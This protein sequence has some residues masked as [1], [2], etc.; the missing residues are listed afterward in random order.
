MLVRARTLKDCATLPIICDVMCVN[1]DH[2]GT[3]FTVNRPKGNTRRRENTNL[4]NK[5]NPST[6]IQKVYSLTHST[7]KVMQSKHARRE[8]RQE[9]GSVANEGG[10]RTRRAQQ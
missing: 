2:R 5:E 1:A 9:D 3:V 4:A 8:E 6:I 10:D 7:T